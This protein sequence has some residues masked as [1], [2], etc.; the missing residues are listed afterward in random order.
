[1]NRPKVNKWIKPKHINDYPVGP[2]FQAGL[3][4]SENADWR[5]LRP[6]IDLDLCIGCLKCYLHCPDGVIFK[7]DNKV[8]IDYSF[9]K[10]C[11]ICAEICPKKAILMIKEE[12]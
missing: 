7:A 12:K 4:T 5:T 3:L 6:T 8:D 11:G 9:C 2:S 1:M 10:G